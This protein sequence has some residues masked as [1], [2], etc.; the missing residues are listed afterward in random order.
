[1]NFAP[2]ESEGLDDTKIVVGTDQTGDEGHTDQAVEALLKRVKKYIILTK[3]ASQGR[4]TC[5]RQ[6]PNGQRSAQQ[7]MILSQAAKVTE[8][9][10][11]ATVEALNVEKD[12]QKTH[13][14]DRIDEEIDDRGAITLPGAGGQAKEKKAPLIDGGKGKKA[15]GFLLVKGSQAT[16]DQR[17]NGGN[18]EGGLSEDRRRFEGQGQPGPEK[19][20]NGNLDG[21]PE[22]GPDHV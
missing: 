5:P 19:A 7:S 9:D 20:E 1:M 8:I 14:G 17:T 22:E 10:E 3:E 6:K 2:L 21:K 12:D 16:S 15:F 13:V 4:N 11:A 18:G